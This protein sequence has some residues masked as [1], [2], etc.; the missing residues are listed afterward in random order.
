MPIYIGEPESIHRALNVIAV[1]L[2]Q[3]GEPAIQRTYIEDTPWIK[4]RW[5]NPR[6]L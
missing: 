6:Y 2:V 1:L 5:P 3:H 4:V